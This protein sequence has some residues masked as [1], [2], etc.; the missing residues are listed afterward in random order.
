M[1]KNIVFPIIV[2]FSLVSTATPPEKITI[3][4]FP[5]ETNRI[6]VANQKALILF[7]DAS[8]DSPQLYHGF[9]NEWHMQ[10][11]PSMFYWS[12]E[13]IPEGFNSHRETLSGSSEMLIPLETSAE[14]L[15]IWYGDRPVWIGGN[16][17]INK[18]KEYKPIEVMGNQFKMW[19]PTGED[20]EYKVYVRPDGKYAGM[21]TFLYKYGGIEGICFGAMINGMSVFPVMLPAK[22]LYGYDSYKDFTVLPPKPNSPFY[23]IRFPD[24]LSD[25]NN[26]I[27]LN[28]LSDEQFGQLFL[29]ANSAEKILVATQ[30]GEYLPKLMWFDP[31]TWPLQKITVPFAPGDYPESPSEVREV[32]T[33]ASQKARRLAEMTRNVNNPVISGSAPSHIKVSYIRL[34][35][36]QT[37]ITIRF[38]PQS[39]FQYNIN[40]DAYITS[41]KGNEHYAIKRVSGANLSP[42]PTQARRGEEEVITMYFEPVP[43]ESTVINLV[44]GPS[45]D[46]INISGIEVPL[47]REKSGQKDNIYDPKLKDDIIM[48]EETQPKFPGGDIEMM[49]WIGKNMHYPENAQYNN[50]QGRVMVQFVVEIDGSIQEAKVTSG[51]DPDL[52]KE[53][54]RLVHSMPRWIPAT[55]GGKQVRS[56][57]TLPIIFRLQR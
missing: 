25:G 6:Q 31:N 19:S 50:K 29:K 33:P 14:W 51:V 27:D 3:P 49:K 48:V 34:S 18:G 12:D 35:P 21:L 10:E 44:E 9:K 56:N 38:T 55:V 28:K 43:L 20:G 46:N 16:F 37:V 13:S 53:A 22:V 2:F 17:I 54:L 42:K 57:Y 36:E 23:E 47:T 32:E 30:V 8:T 15:R 41:N 4:I 40:R 45:R 52:D 7:K 39:N 26:S 11:E 5:K 24:A 1:K